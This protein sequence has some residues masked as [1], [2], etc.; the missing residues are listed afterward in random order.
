MEDEGVG[1]G[2]NEEEAQMEIDEG[3]EGEGETNEENLLDEETEELDLQG[4]ISMIASD[5][6]QGQFAEAL[7]LNS[8]LNTVSEIMRSVQT[9]QVSAATQ[10]LQ[11]CKKLVQF[12]HFCI[13][14]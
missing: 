12:S 5:K 4:F 13:L 6:G 7:T 8:F 10:E 11:V 9:E 2:E 3:Q 1:G 14:L